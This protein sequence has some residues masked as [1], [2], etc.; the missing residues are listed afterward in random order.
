MALAN[1]G[2]QH[3]RSNDDIELALAASEDT[4][5]RGQ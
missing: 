5:V 4:G 2:L 3:G 1:G